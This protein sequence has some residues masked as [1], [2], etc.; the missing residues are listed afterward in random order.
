M[1]VVT[2]ITRLNIG[3]ASPPVIALAAGLRAKGHD[4][5]LITGTPEPAEGSMETDAERQG[6]RLIRLPA[7]RRN[8]HPWRDAAA[9]VALFRAFRRMRPDVVATHMS[10]AGALGRVAARA[11]GVPVVVHTY[12][13]KG[14]H[15]FD[16]RWKELTALTLER[17]LARL[18]SGS[19][20][21]S[22][23]QRQEFIRLA[24]DR[25]ERITVIR[26]GLHLSP[27]LDAQPGEAGL[28]EHLGLA[29][30]VRLIG[31]VGRLVSI[32]GQDVFIRAAASL[33]R[34]R[35]DLHFVLA[36]DGDRRE[37]YEQLA[38]GLELDGRVSFLGWRRDVPAVLA[39]LDVVALPTVNDFEGTPLAVIEA[40]AAGRPVVASDVGGVAEVVRDGVTGRLVP[41][42][43]APALAAAIEEMLEA[44]GAATAMAEAGRCLVTG[45]FQQERMVNETETYFLR[46]LGLRV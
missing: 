46:L 43:D 16:E 29:P 2:V 36:G 6:A 37:A 40:L 42:R 17:R 4:S 39:D 24:I 7:L 41:P 31:V 44:R 30:A 13:G 12:H 34:R 9:L 19:I 18:A 8:P 33:A 15:V 25:P 28:R 20:V 14:F 10:K 3:G 23:M 26:Y 27:F 1:R 45:C 38:R 21:V 5:T 32:K 22:E 11:A 35:S